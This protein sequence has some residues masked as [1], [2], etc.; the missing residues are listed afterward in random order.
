MA[1][2]NFS[3][4]SS[5]VSGTS[6][7]AAW[8]NAA[9][10]WLFWGRRP[11]IATTT[12]SANAQV[13]TLE[14]GSLYAAG[15]EAD[16]DEFVFKAGF[17][18]TGA[19]TLQVVP[20]AGSNVAVAAQVGGAACV[21]GE[22]QSG[23][24][25]KALRLGST[26]QI[27]SGLANKSVTYAKIQDISTT[28]ILLGR[29]T[30]GAGS[31]EEITVAGDVTQAGSTFTI[32]VNA[33]T[34]AKAAQMAA[35]TVKVNNT[36][37]TANA[38]DLA[39]AASTILARL[40]AGDIVAATAAQ[41]LALLGIGSPITNSLGGD[42]ALNNTGTYFTGPTIA[43]G[44]VGTWYASGTVNCKDTAGAANFDVKLWDGTTVMASTR[45]NATAANVQVSISISGYIASPA[46]NIRIS[47]KDST[48]T[49][50]ALEF[51]ASGNS[52]DCTVSAIRIA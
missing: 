41:I 6:I 32:S 8:L 2:T 27:F 5:T 46:G 21:G 13:L 18:N 49:S 26:W 12:G 23:Q 28:N 9:N 37:S 10:K 30:A 38:V 50:G 47:V 22:V 24:V 17:T 45:M 36:S 34:N 33:V 40:A 16:G 11:N 7:V 4:Q 39:M 43:Q 42:V 3:D 48:S 31:V 15:S 44:T 19:L 25:Y 52:K 14:T 20:P 1:D 51:N 29:K 35:D